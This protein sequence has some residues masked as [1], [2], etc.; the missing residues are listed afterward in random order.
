MIAGNN[1]NHF[2]ERLFLCVLKSSPFGVRTHKRERMAKLSPL[3]DNNGSPHHFFSLFLVLRGCGSFSIFFSFLGIRMTGTIGVTFILRSLLLV[4]SRFLDF[5]TGPV[6]K[7]REQESFARFWVNVLKLMWTQYVTM[8][9][10][11]L[12]VLIESRGK[13]FCAFQC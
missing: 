1:R 7:V 8:I 4:K 3:V 10:N 13:L 11:K 12:F 6:T 5:Y 9:V 2:K